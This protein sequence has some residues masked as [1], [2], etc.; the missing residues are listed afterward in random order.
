MADEIAEVVWDGFDSLPDRLKSVVREVF[1][2][3]ENRLYERGVDLELDLDFVT[4]DLGLSVVR[5]GET[6]EPV[7]VNIE[8]LE[9]GVWNGF[10]DRWGNPIEEDHPE[11]PLVKLDMV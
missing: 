6:L 9:Q 8:D 7:A 1:A 3:D 2:E 10:V 11:S 5:I 4:S